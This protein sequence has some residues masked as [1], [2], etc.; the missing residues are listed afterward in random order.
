MLHAGSHAIALDSLNIR[1]DHSARKVRILAEIFKAPSIQRGP[2][3]IHSRAEQ[4][5]FLA[6]PCLLSDALS[7]EP[8]HL[9]VPCGR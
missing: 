1:H 5:V 8:G 4:H 9:R 3:D 2:V 6:V 7:V